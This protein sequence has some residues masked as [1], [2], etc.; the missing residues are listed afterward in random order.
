MSIQSKEELE[1]FYDRPDPW[2]Y[3]T[4]EADLARRARLLAAIPQ[5]EYRQVL[6]VGC[7]NGFVTS[8]L[9]GDAVIGIDLSVNAISYAME[10]ANPRT[11]YRQMSLF[12]IPQAGWSGIFDLV[13]I[14]GVLYDQYIGQGRLLASTIIDDVLAPG[15]HVV[16][17][18][19][20]EWYRPLFPY[21]TVSREYYQY[22][23]Y[24]HVLEV[25]EK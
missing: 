13:V 18:H 23:E 12:D 22:K 3:S 9:P 4:N 24:T 15:G 11:T 21:T 25:Y 20:L 16:S 6:D 8:R 19:I 7:G 5:R 14:T 1:Q 2:N 17:A 10:N